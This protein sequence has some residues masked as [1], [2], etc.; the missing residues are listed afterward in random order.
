MSLKRPSNDDV[1]FNVF[2]FVL[3]FPQ[4][5]LRSFDEHLKENNQLLKQEVL[6]LKVV[7]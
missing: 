1:A 6:A 7:A 3:K 2:F 5:E 4:S